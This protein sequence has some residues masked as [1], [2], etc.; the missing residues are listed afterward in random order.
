MICANFLADPNY[1]PTPEQEAQNEQPAELE[2]V[3]EDQIQD[4]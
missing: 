2:D 1:N 4:A 3:P